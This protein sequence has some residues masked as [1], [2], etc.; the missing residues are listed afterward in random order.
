MFGSASQWSKRRS[1]R[2]G[3]GSLFADTPCR[4]GRRR[5]FYQAQGDI[6]PLVD[7]FQPG[8]DEVPTEL[9]LVQFLEFSV[10]ETLDIL[11]E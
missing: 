11:R 6:L 8:Q 9:S 7:P 1:K 10:R 3:I 4:L 5:I 2:A